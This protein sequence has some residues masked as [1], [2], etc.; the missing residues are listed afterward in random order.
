MLTQM[1]T[2]HAVLNYHLHNMKIEDSATCEHCLEGDET[3]EHYICDCPA[4]SWARQTT[5]GRMFLDKQDLKTLD[6]NVLLQYIR[7]TGR[8]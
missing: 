7:T 4:F 2:G 8:L 1:I 6:F 3:V 5:F